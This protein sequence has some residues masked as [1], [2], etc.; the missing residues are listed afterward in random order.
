MVEEDRVENLYEEGY[1]LLLKML[2]GP[3][4]ESFR[5]WSF[6]GLAIPHEFL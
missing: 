5:S 3:V 6:A 4:R 1:R 2:Q